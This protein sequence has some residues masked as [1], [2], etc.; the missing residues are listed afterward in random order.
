[1]I[2]FVLLFNGALRYSLDFIGRFNG[3]FSCRAL[4]V[5]YS[6]SFGFP[7]EPNDDLAMGALP[8][9]PGAI[10]EGL[11]PRGFGVGRRSRTVSGVAATGN[12]KRL[13]QTVQETHAT[14]SDVTFFRS[15]GYWLNM[16]T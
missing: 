11:T 8:G 10:G 5:T 3:F 9:A 16:I 1:M 7:L 6:T 2:R 15:L 14:L 13:T 4:N 12:P